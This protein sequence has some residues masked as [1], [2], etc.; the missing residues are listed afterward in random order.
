MRLIEVSQ[1]PPEGL[2]VQEEVEPSALHLEAET[3]FALAKGGELRG[4]VERGDDETVHVRG[5]LSARVGLQ[6][7]RCLEPFSLGIEQ[8]LELFFLPHRA[9]QEEEDEVE[10]SER[11]MVVGYYRDNRLDLGEIVR[12]QIFLALPLKRLCALECRG[13]C[14]SCGANRNTRSCDCRPEPDPRLSPLGAL[15]EKESS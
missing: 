14:P 12:E 7:G 9:D 8:E 2:D 6:C 13:L 5:H 4:H 15:I 3:D 1:I 10:V 11:E